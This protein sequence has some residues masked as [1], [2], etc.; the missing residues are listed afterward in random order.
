MELCK[1]VAKGV[2]EKLGGYDV[3]YD[4]LP[5]FGVLESRAQYPGFGVWAFP[6]ENQGGVWTIDGDFSD[7]GLGREYYCDYSGIEMSKKVP[8]SDAV[9]RSM[10]GMMVK[11]GDDGNVRLYVVDAQNGY[12]LRELVR[13]V[14][15][16]RTHEIELRGSHFDAQSLTFPAL[17]DWSMEELDKNIKV[18]DR[19]KLKCDFL[20]ASGGLPSGMWCEWVVTGKRYEFDD[21]TGPIFTGIVPSVDSMYKVEIF[22]NQNAKYEQVNNTVHVQL[23]LLVEW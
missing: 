23:T 16:A 6:D 22:F 17:L 13:D 19:V 2:S 9:F 5:I 1:A 15:V 20:K 3:L 11:D 18:G 7:F 4:M 10:P 8:R 14:D 21:D 12:A